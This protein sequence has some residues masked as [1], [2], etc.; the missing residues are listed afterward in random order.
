M[1]DTLTLFAVAHFAVRAM[2]AAGSV[3]RVVLLNDQP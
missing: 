1:S 2:S 3:L